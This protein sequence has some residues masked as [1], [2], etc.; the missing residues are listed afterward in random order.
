MAKNKIER[1]R[2]NTLSFHVP[3]YRLACEVLVAKYDELRVFEHSAEPAFGGRFD[4]WSANIEVRGEGEHVDRFQHWL[5]SSD[6]GGLIVEGVPLMRRHDAQRAR[7]SGVDCGRVLDE[8]NRRSP[9]VL[10]H[11]VGTR[12]SDALDRAA[13][14]ACCSAELL[15]E[16][17]NHTSEWD[18]VNCQT[19]LRFVPAGV[20]RREMLLPPE[21]VHSVGV[22]RL[23]NIC[24]QRAFEHRWAVDAPDSEL[25]REYQRRMALG[26]GDA[27]EGEDEDA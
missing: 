6:I 2:V 27:A 11:Y 14:V 17:V 18:E 20:I 25:V 23:G 4:D 8:H 7:A 13:G 22:P 21:Y 9:A 15:Q 19:C 24:A 12:A 3:D 5:E 26:D 16:P 10:T 1:K